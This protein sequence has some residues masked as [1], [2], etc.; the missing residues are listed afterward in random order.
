M[1]VPGAG[2]PV[3]VIRSVPV[4]AAPEDIDITNSDGQEVVPSSGS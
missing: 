4:V 3:E 2:F 1:G